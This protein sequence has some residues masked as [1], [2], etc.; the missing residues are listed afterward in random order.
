VGEVGREVLPVLFEVAEVTVPG[1][2]ERGGRCCGPGCGSM[3]ARVTSRIWARL[4]RLR[5]S[6]LPL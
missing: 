6:S 3:P 1:A 2:D 4:L 5:R